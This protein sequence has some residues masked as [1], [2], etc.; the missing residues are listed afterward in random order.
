MEQIAKIIYDYSIKQKILD[1]YGIEKIINELIYLKYLQ[2]YITKI[3]F[4]YKKNNYI[5]S[6][7]NYSKEIRF[8]ILNIQQV[9]MR[10]QKDKNYQNT[11]YLNII[12]LRIICHEVEH[13]YQEKIIY[14]KNC[15]ESFILRISLMND[16]QGKNYEYNPSERLANIKPFKFI[17]TLLKYLYRVPEIL[18]N[19]LEHDKMLQQIKSYK[20]TADNKFILFPFIQFLKL[21]DNEI[22]LEN[23]NWFDTNSEIMLKKCSNDLSEQERLNYGFPISFIEYINKIKSIYELER[24]EKN[25][26]KTFMQPK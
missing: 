22:I 21:A 20:V 2:D 18:V 9:V 11:L 8:S 14:S 5:A 17:E 24:Q 10:F 23:F 7:S 25:Y 19:S 3:I 12:I 6:Y 15:L 26:E 4:Q 13:A 16:K 1:I